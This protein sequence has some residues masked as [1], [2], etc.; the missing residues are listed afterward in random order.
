MEGYVTQQ[1]GWSLGTGEAASPLS[2]FIKRSLRPTGRRQWQ[3]TPVL[4][5][6][7]SHGQRSL[8]GCSPWSRRVGHDWVTS[9]SLS[10]LGEG[11][12]NSLQCS[13]LENPRDGGTWWAAVYGVAQTR[14][15]LKRLSSSSSKV[16]LNLIFQSSTFFFFFPS[17]FLFISWVW[18][19][20]SPWEGDICDTDRK[21]H[22]RMILRFFQERI[23]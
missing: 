22:L 12:G 9:L 13:C 8:V 11:N 15:R 2:S 7:K 18:A 14:T 19:S 6:G 17:L 20:L 23:W 21:W 3:P 4:L 10:C 1:R 16:F 5:P